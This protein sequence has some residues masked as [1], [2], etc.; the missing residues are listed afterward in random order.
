MKHKQYDAM[1]E[2]DKRLLNR[3][4]IVETTIGEIKRLTNIVASKM[5]NVF[6][7]LA[8]VFSSIA[9]YQIKVKMDWR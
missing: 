3:R 5:R 8:N 4:G 1:D 6:D 7:Y 9:T 2:E